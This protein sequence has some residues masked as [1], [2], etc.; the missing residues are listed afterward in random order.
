MEYTKNVIS[1][2]EMKRDIDKHLLVTMIDIFVRYEKSK[3]LMKSLVSH[4]VNPIRD[5]R[6]KDGLST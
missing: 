5:V 6:K 1:N 4:I 3:S 2:G